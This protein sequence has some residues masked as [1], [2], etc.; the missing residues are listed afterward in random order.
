MNELLGLVNLLLGIGHDQTVQV[1][2]LVASVSC[3]R[4]SFTLLDGTLAT[5]SDLCARFR[6][7][8]LERVST[9]ANE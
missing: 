3:V 4:P 5:N 7:H 2:L 6:L 8:F 1:F 9:R